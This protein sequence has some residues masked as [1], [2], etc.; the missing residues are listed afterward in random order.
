MMKYAAISGSVLFALANLGFAATDFTDTAQVV[1]A[2]PI[3]ERITE[4]RQECTPVA[5]APARERSLVG[6]IVGG[7]AGGLVGSQVGR[8]S[9]RTAAT[10][11]GAIAGTIIGDQVGNAD[12]NRVATAQPAQQCRM[13]ETSRD[14][15]RAY[16]VIYRYNGRDISTTMPYHPGNTVRVAVGV[17]ADGPP[18]GTPP[19]P[20]GSMSTTTVREVSTSTPPPPPPGA[21]RYPDGTQ[22]RY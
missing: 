11:A 5:A 14:V 4:Q 19:P 6:P 2:T 1:S 21:Y 7:V 20:P 15:V 8:G 18:A 9:G 12:A 16:N 10:A 3:M 17:A 13:V 22:Y